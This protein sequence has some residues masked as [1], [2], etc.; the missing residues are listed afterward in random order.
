LV[1][2]P[3]TAEASAIA[4]PEKIPMLPPTMPGT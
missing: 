1:V 2:E 4:E 3:F